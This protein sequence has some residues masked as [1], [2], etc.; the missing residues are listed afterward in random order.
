MRQHGSTQQKIILDAVFVTMGAVLL[1]LAWPSDAPAVAREGPSVFL[2]FYIIYLG[3]L[4]L[5]S[6]FYSDAS[7][8]WRS[9]R[10]IC[11]HFTHPRGRHMALFYFALSLVLGI[12]ALCGAFGW[13]E[14]GR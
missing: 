8:V 14:W 6:H 3:V 5:L 1:L 11:E 7:Y 4:F 12:C 9:L 10:W 2:G 13:I